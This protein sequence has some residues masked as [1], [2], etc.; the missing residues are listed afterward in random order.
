ME[1]ATFSISILQRICPRERTSAGKKGPAPAEGIQCDVLHMCVCVYCT[2]MYSRC[3]LVCLNVMYMLSWTAFSF[4]FSAYCSW[5]WRRAQL[6]EPKL[7]GL[8]VP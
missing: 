1:D 3:V 7:R 4:S 6:L 8:S 2:D 5:C